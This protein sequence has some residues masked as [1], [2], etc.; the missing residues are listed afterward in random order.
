MGKLRDALIREAQED[1]RRVLRQIVGPT[2]DHQMVGA[3][4]AFSR[5]CAASGRDLINRQK[6]AAI[7]ALI[8]NPELI[9]TP[10]AE[11]AFREDFKTS[12]PDSDMGALIDE[13]KARRR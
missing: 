8:A 2:T 5:A 9:A 4:S 10:A 7:D 6:A 1:N 13:F 3:G 12:I 11:F